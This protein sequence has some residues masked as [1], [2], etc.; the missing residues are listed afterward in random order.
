M[1]VRLTPGAARP[2]ARRSRRPVAPAQ[3]APHRSVEDHL[4]WRAPPPPRP[5]TL[6]GAL[7]VGSSKV[8]AL[9]A[10]PGEDGTLNILGTGQRESRGVKRGYHRRHGSVRDRRS[11]RRSSRP[12]G[13]PATNIEQVFVGFSAGGMISDVA[14]VEVAIGGRQIGQKD[15]DALLDAGREAIDPGERTILHAVPAFYTLDGLE[16]GQEAARPPRRPARGRHPRRRRRPVAGRESR[17]VRPLRPSRRRGDRR[18]AGRG[19]QGLP[20]R[21]GARAWA[22]LWSS[23]AR[24]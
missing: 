17:P 10:E 4:T 21:G 24:A 3:R 23:S 7:D 20:Q 6:V 8:C 16:R 15:I 1:I 12:S 18:L 13:S 19:R 9:I 5:S 11:A 2:R 22:W 14:N